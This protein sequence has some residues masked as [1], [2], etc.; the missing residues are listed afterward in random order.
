M[1]KKENRVRIPEGVKELSALDYRKY[2]NINSDAV[3]KYPET[4]KALTHPET[5]MLSATEY[6]ELRIKK[7][8]EEQIYYAIADYL[9]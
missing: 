6:E 4:A 2:A 1:K 5:K 9:T 8:T 7:M 3:E